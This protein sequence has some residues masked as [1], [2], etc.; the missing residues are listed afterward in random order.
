MLILKISLACVLLPL[1]NVQGSLGKHKEAAAT[2][3][4][5]FEMFY[6]A[7][8]NNYRTA[9]ARLKLAEHFVRQGLCPGGLAKSTSNK[10]SIKKIFFFQNC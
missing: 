5:A 3:E 1:G 9:Q 2:H 4:A 7:N 6:A 8:G 10:N